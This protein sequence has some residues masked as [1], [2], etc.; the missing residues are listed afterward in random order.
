MSIDGVDATTAVGNWYF[1]RTLNNK[2][3]DCELNPTG[4]V[5][6]NP[7]CNQGLRK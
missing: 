7:S 3:I 4:T 6:C 1:G 2:F 5:A